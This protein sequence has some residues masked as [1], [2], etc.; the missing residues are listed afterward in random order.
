MVDIFKFNNNQIRDLSGEKSAYM[1]RYTEVTMLISSISKNISDGIEATKDQEIE[2][3]ELTGGSEVHAGASV[4]NVKLREVDSDNQPFGSQSSDQNQGNRE[5]SDF[6]SAQMPRT[7]AEIAASSGQ[8]SQN[9]LSVLILH[10][11]LRVKS[12]SQGRPQ[13]KHLT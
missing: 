9:P 3:F 11:K 7:A 5:L 10:V 8:F 12:L 4:P 6:L 1:N 2:T 13:V